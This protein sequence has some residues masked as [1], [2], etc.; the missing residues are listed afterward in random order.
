MATPFEG[1][2]AANVGDAMDRLGIMDSGIRAMWPGARVIGPAFTVWTREGDN[3][4]LHQA[5]ADAPEGAVIVISGGGLTTRALMGELMA[6]RALHKG[7]KGFVFDA[8]IRDREDIEK[9][10][11]PVWARAVTPAGPYKSGPFRLQVPIACGGVAVM[12]GD[13]IVA[14]ADGV[15]VIPAAD[16]DD[17]AV[18][19]QAVFDDETSRREKIWG[20]EK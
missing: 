2:P 20:D 17:I 19:A 12:P 15:V 14:D 9:M 10:G 8:A 1:I 18:K 3:L 4:G 7:I 6:G 5:I 16:V 11:M 13:F